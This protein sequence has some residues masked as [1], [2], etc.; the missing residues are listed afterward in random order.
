MESRNLQNINQELNLGTYILFYQLE[1]MMVDM[2]IL[3]Y[4]RLPPPHWW[5]Y[6]VL[7]CMGIIKHVLILLHEKLL[8]HFFHQA[9]H[10]L[11]FSNGPNFVPFN[12]I[13]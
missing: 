5:Y 13:I 11:L 8:K 10:I 1:K 4:I 2:Y 12:L 3:C 9:W 7:A 6:S